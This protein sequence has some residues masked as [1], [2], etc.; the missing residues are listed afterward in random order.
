MKLANDPDWQIQTLRHFLKRV[1]S[2]AN[3]LA[4]TSLDVY[5]MGHYSNLEKAAILDSRI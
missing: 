3:Y 5:K 2:Y 1:L 4:T